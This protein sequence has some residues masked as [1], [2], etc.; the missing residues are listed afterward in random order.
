M[1]ENQEKLPNIVVSST[2][3]KRLWSN[4]Q[5]QGP[6]FAVIRDEILGRL[7]TIQL[8]LTS[9]PDM[10][11]SGKKLPLLWR[12]DH[13]SNQ[14]AQQLC[15]TFV[16]CDRD[17]IV[18]LGLCV[19]STEVEG[20]C[21]LFY[22]GNSIR[23]EVKILE[24]GSS[25]FSRNQGIIETSLLQD[26]TVLCIGLGSGGASIVND[27]A[28]SGV[29]SFI[30]W[31]NDRLEATNLGRHICTLQ[32]IGRLKTSAMRDHILSINP[33]ATVDVIS[34]DVKKH[35]GMRGILAQMVERADVVIAA[36][37]NNPSRFVIN[38]ITW[39]LQKTTLFGR[40]FHRACGGDVIQVVPERNTP[41]YACHTEER[42]VE[43]E[44]S[45][46]RDANAIA[47]ADVVVPIEPG[48]HVDI[49]PLA[50]MISRLALF[51]LIKGTESSLISTAEELDAPLYLWG[52]RRE[53]TFS[54]WPPMKR[55][56]SSMSILR[57]YGISV[58]KN[59]SCVVCGEI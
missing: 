31:D 9:E 39:E 58:P 41:C 36:T 49:A 55:S 16:D 26:R 52:N 34:D 6:G 46:V 42:V 32:D 48:L 2:E 50:N 37:D 25:S 27:L 18:F 11:P 10:L 8:Y 56:F 3:I 54:K 53:H 28:R 35:A 5:H 24:T 19:D 13:S 33:F 45:S 12:I 21:T 4:G 14:T 20:F 51:H 1:N 44:I 22:R 29:G 59:P 47:Y 17:N 43:E 30:L 57:W 23:H 15:E 38:E 40:A 7:D